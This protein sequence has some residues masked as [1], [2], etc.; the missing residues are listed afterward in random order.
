[1][2]HAQL[3]QVRVGPA[4]GVLMRMNLISVHDTMLLFCTNLVDLS[5]PEPF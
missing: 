2:T 3:L 5:W 1:M 4:T